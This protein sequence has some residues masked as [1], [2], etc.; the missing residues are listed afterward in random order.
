M[1]VVRNLYSSPRIVL[2]SDGG[3][4]NSALSSPYL[5]ALCCNDDLTAVRK[6]FVAS[7]WSRIKTLNQLKLSELYIVA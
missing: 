3:R 4:M 5:K 6:M 7:D 1:R 2:P